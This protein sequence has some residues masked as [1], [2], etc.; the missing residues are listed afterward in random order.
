MLLQMHWE[1]IIYSTKY[2][3][4]GISIDHISNILDLVSDN[5]YYMKP[6]SVPYHPKTDQ[7]ADLTL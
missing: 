5:S 3:K 4:I 7:V 2:L 1:P 6:H